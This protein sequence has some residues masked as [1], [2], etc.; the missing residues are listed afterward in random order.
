MTSTSE[1]S[2]YYLVQPR[3][4]LEPRI[5]SRVDPALQRRLLE[6]VLLGNTEPPGSQWA[7]DDYAAAVKLTF[8]AA[9]HQYDETRSDDEFAQVFGSH[10]LT[11][12]LFDRWWTLQR[13][14][15][16]GWLKNSMPMLEEHLHNIEKSG[17]TMVD[18]WVNSMR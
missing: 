9:L 1:H 3:P 17:N 15:F 13:I 8:L 5:S 2:V 6:P 16:G 12:S 7:E 10:R 18:L 14:P 4:A 11:P